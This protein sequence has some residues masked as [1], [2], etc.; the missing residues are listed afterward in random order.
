[1][2][3]KLLTDIESLAELLTTNRKI[4]LITHYNPDGDAIGSL[5]GMYHY[6]KKKNQQVTAMVPNDF[7]EFL[8]WMKDTNQIIVFQNQHKKALDAIANAEIIIC[9]D[10]NNFQRLKDI[11]P[12]LSESGAIK[13]LIDHHPD[14][15][16]SYKVKIHDTKSSSTAELVFRFIAGAGDKHLID[17]T[18]GECIYTGIMT[19]TGCFNFNSSNPETFLI[20]AD[21][22]TCGINKDK[23]FNY[24]YNN[25]SQ[26][27]MKLMGYCLNEK[28]VVLPKFQAA[29]I[30]LT[31]A[32]MEKNNFKTGDSEGFVN[33]PLS[34]KGINIAA[35]ITEKKD[36]IRISLRSRGGF[37][38]N[39]FC[40]KHFDGGGHKN[41]AGGESKL[42]M[43]DTIEKFEKLLAQYQNEIDALQGFDS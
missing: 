6:L 8:S 14:P 7:P 37:P 10:F 21:L 16:N 36:H 5:M 3:E 2:N 19:D 27:R 43:K 31:R 28:M 33:L 34:I 26:H 15:E 1:L 13:I 30:S 35:L 24:V 9:L 40:E 11:G 20:V 32:E 39:I 38:V 22:L 29:Y 12:K 42:S 18:I 17:R 41:A 4:L 25:F 23:I